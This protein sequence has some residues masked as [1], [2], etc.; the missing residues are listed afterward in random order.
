M[1]CAIDWV[2]LKIRGYVSTK[3]LRNLGKGDWKLTWIWERNIKFDVSEWRKTSLS[4]GT[5]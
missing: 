3:N 1:K 5:N 4:N 2:A